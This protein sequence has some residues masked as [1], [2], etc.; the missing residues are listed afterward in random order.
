MFNKFYIIFAVTAALLTS[1]HVYSFQGDV[2]KVALQEQ[3][4]IAVKL[5]PDLGTRLIFPFILDDPQLKPPLNYKLTNTKDF[6]V[7]RSLDAIIGQNVFLVTTNGR[8]GDIGK[9]YISIAGYHLAL[10]LDVSKDIDD[11]ISDIYFNLT[12][13]DREFLIAK[14]IANIKHSLEVSYQR[15]LT[16]NK[17]FISDED[18]ARIINYGT[19]QKNIKQL[20]RGG[21]DKFATADIYLDKF[22][23][24]KKSV[25][26]LKFWVE[27]YSQKF[28][29]SSLL[30]QAKSIRGDSS[31]LEGKMK[32]FLDRP[33]VDE[34]IFITHDSLLVADSADL[35]ITL[36][37]DKDETFVLN[38]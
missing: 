30:I 28:I 21:K 36:T 15:R 27:H 22:M 16:H 17:E 13:A 26:A 24:L 18:L 32:C 1:Q 7:A 3:T 4:Q 14:E 37:N 33:R 23:Y 8:V 5:V 25:F 2:L 6:K 9:L 38:Y 35:I 20:F 34:C 12:K 31:I 29:T 19:K 11:H 10:N